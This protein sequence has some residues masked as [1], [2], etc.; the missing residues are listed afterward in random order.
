MNIDKISEYLFLDSVESKLVFKNYKNYLKSGLVNYLALSEGGTIRTMYFVH[1]ISGY[2]QMIK[3][4]GYSD[5]YIEVNVL[6]YEKFG[7]FSKL[8]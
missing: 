5:K 4:N 8:Q 6:L 7:K 3:E 1:L 2:L